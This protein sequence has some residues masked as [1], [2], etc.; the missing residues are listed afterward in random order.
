MV[1]RLKL[2]LVFAL[3]INAAWGQADANKG[4][5]GGTVVDYSLGRRGV[6]AV[7]RWM[8]WARASDTSLTKADWRAIAAARG[9]R[10]FRNEG[11]FK[12]L[13]K[14]DQFR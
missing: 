6:S 13:R 10:R 7:L 4:N 14:A 2:A 8:E 3:S 9:L 5:I 11:R 12:R 1:A